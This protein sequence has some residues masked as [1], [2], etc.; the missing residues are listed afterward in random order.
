MSMVSVMNVRSGT[1]PYMSPQQVAGKKPTPADD[2]YALGAALYHLLTSK[3]PF[4]QGDITDQVKNTAPAPIAERLADLEINSKVPKDVEVVVLL[5][6]G[7]KPEERPTSVKEVCQRLESVSRTIDSKTKGS[8]VSVPPSLP[9]PATHSPSQ[10]SVPQN[11]PNIN[12]GRYTNFICP[13]CGQQLKAAREHGGLTGNCPLCGQQFVIPKVSNAL[14]AN[15]SAPNN[16]VDQSGEERNNPFNG[17]EVQAWANSLGMKF[18]PVPG[19]HVLFSIW[20]TRVKDYAAYAKANRGVNTDWQNPEF[21]GQKITP[22]VNCPVVGVSWGDAK[23]FCKWLTEKEQREGILAGGQKYRLPTDA[24]WSYAVGIGDQEVG[25]TPG[26]KDGT[27]DVYPWGT[28]WPPP[29]GAGNFADTTAKQAFGSDFEVIEGYDDGYATTAPVGSFNA[30][31]FGLYDLSGNVWEWCEDWY[32]T[33]QKH[34]VLRGGSWGVSVS[35]SLLSA[36]RGGFTPEYRGYY[37]GFRIVLVVGG[38]GQ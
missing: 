17:N 11:V 31:E 16:Q 6:L 7:K 26:D 35:G 12:N 3:P 30:N 20:E 10:T 13:H 29:R 25:N 27:E 1:L 4:Y 8:G 32:D 15:L 23:G 21:E 36:Y 28:Q 19:T 37:F 18:V 38:A 33:V 24:E 5:C 9:A 2:I 34:R 22:D 14:A